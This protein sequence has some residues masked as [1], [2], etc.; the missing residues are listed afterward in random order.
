MA[1]INGKSEAVVLR[2]F[3]LREQDL[4][5]VFFTR[6]AGKIRG[7]A[8]G[9]RGGKVRR[10]G[11]VFLPAT[12]VALDWFD[13]RRSELVRIDECTLVRSYFEDISGSLDLSLIHSLLLELTDG[14]TEAQDPS[15]DLY[16][17]LRLCLE[18]ACTAGPALVTV[19][20][21]FEYW[22][23]RLSGL[24]PGNDLCAGCAAPLGSGQAVWLHPEDGFR[25]RNCSQTSAA[26]YRLEA[27]QVG[28]LR[29]F[30][31]QGLKE[32]LDGSS[33]DTVSLDER[34]EQPLAGCLTHHL[35]RDI[36][37]HS[38]IHALRGPRNP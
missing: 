13:N 17:L 38:A 8:R 24:F 5:V 27:E 3:D 34:L 15:D 11:G 26:G 18:Q 6:S 7:V 1:P 30:S 10:F 23:L 14:F 21:Y 2:T 9:A 37:S 22:L 20:H 12:V 25:C 36:R 33:P 29:A 32:V 28:R 19:R 16:R 35:G 4:I 31:R